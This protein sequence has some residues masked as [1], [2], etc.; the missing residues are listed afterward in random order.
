MAN[1]A[2]PCTAADL[3]P[4]TTRFPLMRTSPQ[5]T[6]AKEPG[7]AIPS[8]PTVTPPPVAARPLMP[9]VPVPII[10]IRPLP[11]TPAVAGP[12]AV[13]RPSTPLPDATPVLVFVE[14]IPVTP[15]DPRPRPTRPTPLPG[16]RP[17]T[18]CPPTNPA[19]SLA[20]DAAVAPKS[21]RTFVAIRQVPAGSAHGLI[22]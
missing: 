16:P 13:V 7:L 17:P 6:P 3:V 9:H 5:N 18:N 20:S 14:P 19:A 4:D 21:V 2:R 8:T 1:S 22:A 11:V 12:V 15:F 10:P